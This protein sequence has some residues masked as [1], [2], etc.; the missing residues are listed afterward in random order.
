MNVVNYIKLIYNFIT[1]GIFN[2]IKSGVNIIFNSFLPNQIKNITNT[3]GLKNNI[4]LN[5]LIQK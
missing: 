2:E 4:F 3:L 5:G 1:A